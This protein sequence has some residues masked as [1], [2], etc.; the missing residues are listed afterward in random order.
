MALQKLPQVVG[1]FELDRSKPGSLPATK[2]HQGDLV[3]SKM[4]P[5][6]R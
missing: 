6:L 2:K 3:V 5:T 4:N 1:Y